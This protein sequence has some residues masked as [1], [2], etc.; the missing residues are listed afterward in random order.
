MSPPVRVFGCS[1]GKQNPSGYSRGLCRGPVSLFAL[2]ALFVLLLSGCGYKMAADMP[3]VLGDGTKTLKIKGVDYPT[4]TP[5]LP[6][7]LRSKLRDE[8]NAR[9]IARWVDSGPADYEMQ[10]NVIRFTNREWMRSDQDQ[11]ILMSMDLVIEAIVYEGSTNKEVWR[12]GKISYNDTLDTKDTDNERTA[13]DELITQT[14][15]ILADRLRRT[16]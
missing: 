2:L 3:S 9:Y 7:E 1:A 10:I 4:M 12:S 16:F 6:Y 8:I 13:A 5:W 11:S 15:R 14:V